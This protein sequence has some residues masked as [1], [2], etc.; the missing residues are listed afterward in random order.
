MTVLK[1][2]AASVVTEVENGTLTIGVKLEGYTSNDCKFDHFT[3][4]YL[5]HKNEE[6]DAIHTLTKGTDAHSLIYD[7]NG[8]RVLSLKKGFYIVNGKKIIR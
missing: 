8:R 6:T 5:G 3:Q 7:L 1:N 4:E 2:D